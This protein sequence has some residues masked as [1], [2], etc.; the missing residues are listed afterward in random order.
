MA[1]HDHRGASPAT[2]SFSIITVSDSR[3]ANTDTSGK[4]IES[5]ASAKGHSVV[6][7]LIVKDDATEI[8]SSLRKSVEGPSDV[9]VFTGG[10]GIT[11]RDVTPETIRPMM[12]KVIDGFGELFRNLSYMS[13]GGASIM[14]RSLAGIIGRKPVFCLPGSP[15]AVRLAMESIILPEIGHLVRESRR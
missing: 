15:D 6:S 1:V 8:L 7:R 3:E 14:S 10:T 13:I 4:L 12:D 5:L 11:S 9:I 2:V